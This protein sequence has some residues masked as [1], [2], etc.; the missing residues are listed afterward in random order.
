MALIYC[1]ECGKEM[2]ANATA[3]PNCGNPNTLTKEGK[4]AE[5]KRKSDIDTKNGTIA[6]VCTIVGVLL[7]WILV[8]FLWIDLDG[9]ELLDAFGINTSN[10]TITIKE[11]SNDEVKDDI[12]EWLGFEKE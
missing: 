8:A 2:S 3:C 7:F 12:M 6:I 5:I 10:N 11:K 1:R 9:D 4:H